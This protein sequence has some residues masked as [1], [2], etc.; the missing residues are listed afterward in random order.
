MRRA[1]TAGTRGGLPLT[2]SERALDGAMGERIGLLDKGSSSLELREP[3]NICATELQSL[4]VVAKPPL[5][6]RI[7]RRPTNPNPH[8]PSPRARLQIGNLRPIPR[9]LPRD[10][11]DIAQTA[12]PSTCGSPPAMST[13]LS[14]SS[15]FKHYS[16]P[17]SPLDSA[18]VHHW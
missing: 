17:A 12:S 3:W 11:P 9:I 16:W 1:G 2:A 6:R 18:S 13:T 5:V 4:D 15:C 8:A 10:C 14:L 7:M